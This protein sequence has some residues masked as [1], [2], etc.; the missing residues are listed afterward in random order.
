MAFLVN[1]Y[2]LSGLKIKLRT[3]FLQTRREVL[4]EQETLKKVLAIT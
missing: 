4:A 2:N 1:A 3:H